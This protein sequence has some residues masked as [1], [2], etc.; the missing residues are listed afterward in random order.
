MKEVKPEPEME[1]DYILFLWEWITQQGGPLVPGGGRCTDRN[2]GGQACC[3]SF[4][5]HHALESVAA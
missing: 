3:R 4:P 5:D 1:V 2:D